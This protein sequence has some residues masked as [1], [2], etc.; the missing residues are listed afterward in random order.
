MLKNYF[1]N[2]FFTSILFN[3]ELIHNLKIQILVQ[4]LRDSILFLQTVHNVCELDITN[5][6]ISL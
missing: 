3:L 4:K 2:N 6:K 1:K 5:S